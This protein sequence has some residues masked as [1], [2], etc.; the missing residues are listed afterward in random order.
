MLGLEDREP[1]G[2][3]LGL[4]LCRG[5]TKAGLTFSNYMRAQYAPNTRSDAADSRRR[6]ELLSPRNHDE[7]QMSI[8][9]DITVKDFPGLCGVKV[10]NAQEGRYA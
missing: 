9:T 1:D 3:C 6:A 5:E 10:S 8:L 2:P 4:P 7:R